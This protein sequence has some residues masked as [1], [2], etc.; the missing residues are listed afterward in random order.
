[1]ANPGIGIGGVGAADIIALGIHDHQHA[2]F[3][4]GPA[5]PRQNPHALMPLRLEK[6]GLRL[7]R[8]NPAPGRVKA[9]KGEILDGADGGG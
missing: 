9:C 8:G 3:D 4:G 7:D 1:M 5:K 2:G 6:G